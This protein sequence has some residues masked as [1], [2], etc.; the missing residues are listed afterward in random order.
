M[1]RVAVGTAEAGRPCPACRFPLRHD[2]DATTYKRAFVA[3]WNP[4]AGRY[5]LEPYAEGEI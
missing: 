5:G 1:S 3:Q 2:T 4:L